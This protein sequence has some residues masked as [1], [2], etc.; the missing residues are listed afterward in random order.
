[1]IP[2][3]RVQPNVRDEQSGVTHCWCGFRLIFGNLVVRSAIKFV[4][5]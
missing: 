2:M 4:M 5:M 1:M 3:P